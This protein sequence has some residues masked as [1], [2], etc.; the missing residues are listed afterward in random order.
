MYTSFNQNTSVSF[1][2]HKLCFHYISMLSYFWNYG[3]HGVRLVSFNNYVS[4]INLRI[5]IQF[6][7]ADWST[8][9]SVIACS[10]CVFVGIMT[11]RVLIIDL[12]KRWYWRLIGRTSWWNYSVCNSNCCMCQIPR[13]L[14]GK[15]QIFVNF[16]SGSLHRPMFEEKTPQYDITVYYLRQLKT[17]HASQ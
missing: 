5:A 15:C 10:V 8:A 4:C 7:P 13:L 9:D 14:F 3:Q 2:V 1:V 17:A 16:A 12:Y 11:C 6:N